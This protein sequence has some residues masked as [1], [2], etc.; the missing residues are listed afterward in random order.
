MRTCNSAHINYVKI[1]SERAPFSASNKLLSAPIRALLRA[2]IVAYLR[3]L[4][5]VGIS[6]T[7]VGFP[8]FSRFLA[9][10]VGTGTGI[11]PK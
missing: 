11:G 6:C 4:T 3:Y 7:T 5:H 10:R 2:G 1:C 8:R 9:A